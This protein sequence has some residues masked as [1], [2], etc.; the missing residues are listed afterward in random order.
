MKKTET[1]GM[2]AAVPFEGD[3]I[4]GRLKN[5]RNKNADGLRWITGKIGKTEIVFFFSG[6]GKTNAAHA[7]AVLIREYSPSLVINFGIGGAYPSS[8]L[9]PGDIAVA[10]QEFY[11]DEGV[12]LKDGFHTLQTIGIPLMKVGRRRYFNAFPLDA[13][14][15]REMAKAARSAGCRPA[16]GVFATVSTC[17]GTRKR[18]AELSK[19][20]SAICENMEGAA[21]A[22]I[23]MLYGIPFVE[24]RG[25]SN[26]VEE[27][28]TAKWD[29]PL[30]SGNCQKTVVAFVNS[31]NL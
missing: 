28:D 21:I 24:V 11:A 19:R 14:L 16:E 29:I 4:V 12:S 25:I 22:H 20:F 2:I 18:A 30:A 31:R 3:V 8:G 5:R 17:T 26:I 27:R 13:G 10:S 6:I 15:R 1:L 9:R 23:C 7:A